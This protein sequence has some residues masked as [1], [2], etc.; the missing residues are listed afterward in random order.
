MDYLFYDLAFQGITVLF[1]IT[2]FHTNHFETEDSNSKMSKTKRWN[3]KT[4]WQEADICAPRNDIH[5]SL[6]ESDV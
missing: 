4:A 2:A 3:V 6:R 1:I 5:Y